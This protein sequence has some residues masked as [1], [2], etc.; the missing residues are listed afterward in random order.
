MHI[1]KILSVLCL[2]L[3]IT[4]CEFFTSGRVIIPE[5]VVKRAN[6]KDLLGTYDST[7]LGRGEGSKTTARLKITDS[8]KTETLQNGTTVDLLD[9]A[10]IG[11]IEKPDELTLSGTLALSELPKKQPDQSTLYIASVYFD[12]IGTTKQK[13][14]DKKYY[15][16]IVQKDAGKNIL[17]FWMPNSESK[18][19][20]NIANGP[21][22]LPPEMSFKVKKQN[23][24][25]IVNWARTS[26]RDYVKFDKPYIFKK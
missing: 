20:K 1:R 11:N 9:I 23:T 14:E 5:T 13:N 22:L 24:Q 7:T 4:G 10:Y 25:S 8:G 12:M 3:F 19:I 26:G 2:I 15:F 21:Q 18:A 6:F 17:G 16:F